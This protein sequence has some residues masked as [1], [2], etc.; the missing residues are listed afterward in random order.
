MSEDK[1]PEVKE[2]NRNYG[3]E[4]QQVAKKQSDSSAQWRRGDIPDI[5]Q[6][7]TWDKLWRPFWMVP[8]AFVLVALLGGFFLPAWERTW[9]W[10]TLAWAFQGGPDAAREVL[11]TISASTISVIGLVFS[12]TMVVLQLIANRF[13]PRSLSTFLQ[14]RIVQT[15]LGIYLGTFVF[16]LTTIRVVWS[17]ADDQD[18][19]VPRLSVTIAFFLALGCLG[20]FLAFIWVVMKSMKVSNT[21]SSIADSTISRSQALYPV[22]SDEETYEQHPAWSPSQDDPREVLGSHDHGYIAWVDYKKIEKWAEDHDAVITVDHRV[23]S[24]VQMG[25][26]LMRVWF[27]GELDKEARKQ[28]QSGI[29]IRD[30]REIYQDVAFG[31][32]Q[33]TDTATTALT[34]SVNDPTTAQQVVHEIHRIFRYLVQC[35]ET[36]P[37]FTDTEGNVRVVHE[38]QRISWMLTSVIAEI[39]YDCDNAPQVLHQ[40][41]EV[42][43]DLETVS[44]SK[45]DSALERCRE[46]VAQAL[47]N[48]H[49]NY[50]HE[51]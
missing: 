36:S 42:L 2:S 24:G 18:A 31:L 39:C 8:A 28:L 33:L 3:T 26:P 40:L 38:P 5:P 34:P 29:E 27:D 41:G 48:N 7:T 35:E 15:T 25:Q 45:Y 16:S 46:L 22:A 1:A 17:S 23:G 30:D 14:S 47:E 9:D 49:P 21:I 51:F 10:G 44:L 13:S 12:N 50:H 37:Y 6:E 43:D 20:Y 19:F 11:G 32:R 4:A